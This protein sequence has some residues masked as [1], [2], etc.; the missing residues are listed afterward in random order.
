[1]GLVL[2]LLLLLLSLSANF[3]DAT[4]KRRGWADEAWHLT[5]DETA[6]CFRGLELG[7]AYH[8]EFST[9]LS[10]SKVRTD[11]HSHAVAF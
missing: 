7:K 10:F 6:H 11:A 5:T 1:M 2:L 9:D 4:R 3:V 8:Y